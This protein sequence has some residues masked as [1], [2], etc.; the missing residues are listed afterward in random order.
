MIITDAIQMDA[1]ADTM[2][3]YLSQ[4]DV[5]CDF[6][7][8]IV[9]RWSKE[10]DAVYIK[11]DQLTKEIFKNLREEVTI[12]MNGDLQDML[13]LVKCPYQSSLWYH[14]KT[15]LPL[16]ENALGIGGRINVV[17]K[18][19]ADIDEQHGLSIFIVC[20]YD[21]QSAYKMHKKWVQDIIEV[22][23]YVC[24]QCRNA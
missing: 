24:M 3:K 23:M 21:L 10:V 14:R 22:C 13:L 15:C 1:I 12:L 7:Y 6:D 20:G 19:E 5:L 16:F 17:D 11:T 8:H 9:K 2:F 4:R 18:V